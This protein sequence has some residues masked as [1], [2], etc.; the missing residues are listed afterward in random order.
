MSDGLV[1]ILPSMFR[2]NPG[3]TVSIA[4]WCL[5]ILVW[6]TLIVRPGMAQTCTPA[7]AAAHLVT[8]GQ[9]Q[10]TVNP[11]LPPQEYLNDRG[12]LLGLDIDLTT[13][14]AKIMC[15]EPVYIRMDSQ[16]M[17]PGLAAGRFDMVDNGLFWTAERAKRYVMVPFAQQGFSI[18][19]A[20]DSKLTI[21]SFDDLAG[22][23]VA[24]EFGSYPDR[25][26][27][28]AAAELA[29]KGGKPVD[30]RTFANGPE[31]LAALRAGQVDAIVSNDENAQSIAKRG[32]AKIQATGLWHAEITFTFHD[33]DL[34]EAAAKALTEV[35]AAGTYDALF[36]KYGM[37]RLE[38]KTFAIRG[39]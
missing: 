7:V 26:A 31:S 18:M 19:T 6:A 39:P 16:G 3:A 35:R 36:D 29:A 5:P 23:R 8:P 37:A 15:L 4:K 11:N 32:G 21:R 24:S 12:E 9:M 27:H 33:R 22:L 20:L 1:R 17:I 14:M 30:I 34:A 10:M 28:Q 25:M 38:T 2:N 13:A